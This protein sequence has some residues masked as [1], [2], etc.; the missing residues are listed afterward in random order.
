[1]TPNPIESP[2]MPTPTLPLAL[3]GLYPRCPPP[4]LYRQN[5]GLIK[6]AL[7]PSAAVS[8][9]LATNNQKE[10]HGSSGLWREPTASCEYFVKQVS[11]WS[12]LRSTNCMIIRG[13]SFHQFLKFVKIRKSPFL[14]I[15]VKHKTRNVPFSTQ[16]QSLVF[17]VTVFVSLKIWASGPMPTL[18]CCFLLHCVPKTSTFSFF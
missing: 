12:T 14:H 6:P 10:L 2:S 8:Q 5:V 17:I 1:M 9:E 11:Y 15:S 7:N 16:Q 13:I 4:S 3:C 18:Q